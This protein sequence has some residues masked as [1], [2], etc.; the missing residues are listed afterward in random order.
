MQEQDLASLASYCPHIL[1]IRNSV[2]VLL[3]HP[4][5]SQLPGRFLL[6]HTLGTVH[7]IRMRPNAA[8]NKIPKL[9]FFLLLPLIQ[10]DIEVSKYCLHFLPNTRHKVKTPFVTM[11]SINLVVQSMRNGRSRVLHRNTTIHYKRN[12]KCRAVLLLSRVAQ[13]FP[14]GSYLPMFGHHNS[15]HLDHIL[16]KQH[17]LHA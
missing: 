15:Q 10:I 12:W 2:L 3:F 1:S 7:G 17:I 14:P 8:T 13:S 11:M 5:S 16:Q 4:A 6:G 9:V